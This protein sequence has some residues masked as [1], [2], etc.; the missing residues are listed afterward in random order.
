MTGSPIQLVLVHGW[1]FDGSFWDPMRAELADFDTLTLDLGFRGQESLDEV[2]SVP[3]R[4]VVGHS[5]GSLW[6]LTRAPFAWDVFVAINGFSK[7]CESDGFAPAVPT[8]TL[9]RMI[10]VLP[11]DPEGVTRDFLGRCGHEEALSG[12]DAARLDE[13]LHWLRDWDA[14]SVLD[15]D[16]RP[17]LILASRDDP[18]VPAAMTEACFAGHPT[19][20]LNW[21]EEGGHLLPQTAP[22]WC[23][24]RIR[25]FL[26]RV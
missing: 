13:G 8:R 12:L 26:G 10:R 25:A 19:L 20:T 14:R 5:L 4:V 11:R 23:A 9:D 7:F 21:R 1:G 2:S 16:A 24:E 17:G 15:S 18:I 3:R 6:L 22:G